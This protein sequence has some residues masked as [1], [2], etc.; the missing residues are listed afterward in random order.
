[1]SNPPFFFQRLAFWYSQCQRQFFV[2][3]CVDVNPWWKNNENLY[4]VRTPLNVLIHAPL[5]LFQVH[6]RGLRSEDWLGTLIGRLH[7]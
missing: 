7:Y 3:T 5:A 4:C 6:C 1:M 2:A